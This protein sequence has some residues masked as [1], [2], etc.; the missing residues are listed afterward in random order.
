MNTNTLSDPLFEA[1]ANIRHNPKQHKAYNVSA[2]L[3]TSTTIRTGNH[4]FTFARL[5]VFHLVTEAEV[6]VF[7]GGDR[8]TG[9]CRGRRGRHRERHRCSTFTHHC[10]SKTTSEIQQKNRLSSAALTTHVSGVRYVHKLYV[11]YNTGSDERGRRRDEL[12]TST[13]TMTCTHTPR[14]GHRQRCS[15]HRLRQLSKALAMAVA[16]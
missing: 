5:L 16:G 10:K 12:I 13:T 1:E 14:H 4:L 7:T 11:G 3:T 15:D 9:C 8:L 6:A 2:A